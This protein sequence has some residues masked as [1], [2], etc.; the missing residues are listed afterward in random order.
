[1]KKIKITLIIIGIL[2]SIIFIDTIQAII[3]KNSPIISWREQLKDSDNW[4]DKGII[5]DTYYCTKEEDIITV[6]WNFKTTK[7]TC[8]IDNT[9]KLIEPQEIPNISMSIKEG[10]LSNT[11][12]TIIITDTSGNNNTYG[13][14]YRIDKKINNNW[15]ELDVVIE[16]NYGFNSIG[17]I[18][19]ENNTLELTHNWEWLY[20]R[21]DNGDYRLVKEVNNKCFSTNFTITDQNKSEPL[22]IK[23]ITDT[24]KNQTDFACAQAIE[25]FYEDANY[26]YTFNCIMSPYIIVEYTNGAKENIKAALNNNHIT[27]SD[28]D[29][30][31][32]HYYKRK[33][34]ISKT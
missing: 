17:Y 7:Y 26:E 6:S 8:P 30:Y 32:I 14:F 10:T 4:V 28:L 18:V 23:T 9:K 21:L 33:K 16:G 2:I 3:F 20:G 13:E 29:E 5:I 27:I 19:D 24:T 11:G 12:V 34:Q 1:M 22:I 31:N 25:V 15:Q